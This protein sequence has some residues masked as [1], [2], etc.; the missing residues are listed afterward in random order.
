MIRADMHVHTYYSDG[1]QSPADVIA[2][3]RRAGVGLISVTDHDNANARGEVKKLA[4]ASDI[5]AVDGEEVSAYDNNIKVHILG[6][7]MDCGCEKYVR[8]HKKLYDGAEERAFDVLKKLSAAGVRLSYG[9]VIR[10]RKSKLSPLHGMY[11][12]TAGARKGYARSPFDFYARYLGYGKPGFSCVGRPSPEETAE[13]ISSCGGVCSLAHPGRISLDKEG[14]QKLIER[15]LPC[16]L[17]GIE[18]VYSGHTAKETQYYKE[19]AEKYG[20]LVTGGSDT[21]YAEG[22]RRV[23]EPA[24]YPDDKLLSALKII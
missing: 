12:A 3:A 16:G 13:L 24:F 8:F 20:L 6:Y 5:I 23:G 14:V 17:S 19:L 21:H 11:I 4:L 15:L 2:A 10:E 22:N 9:E 1:A 18:A 7:G